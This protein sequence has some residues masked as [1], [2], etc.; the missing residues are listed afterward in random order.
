MRGATSHQIRLDLEVQAE[1]LRLGAT[2]RFSFL[3][4]ATWRLKKSNTMPLSL[5]DL[6]LNSGLT[7]NE[8]C[9]WANYFTSRISIF[10]FSE[11]SGSLFVDAI[12]V[13]LP[14]CSNLLVT[15]KSKL[16]VLSWSFVDLHRAVKNLSHP[17]EVE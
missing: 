16:A 8:L 4:E 15:P 13:N 14:T 7:T 1:E 5:A 11:G 12:F 3:W 10:I 17:G 2:H 9:L 6:G